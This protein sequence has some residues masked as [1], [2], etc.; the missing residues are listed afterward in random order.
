MYNIHF[1]WNVCF[2][3]EAA[4]LWVISSNIRTFMYYSEMTII[5]KFDNKNFKVSKGNNGQ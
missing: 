4:K 5:N 2:T 3:H 1:F